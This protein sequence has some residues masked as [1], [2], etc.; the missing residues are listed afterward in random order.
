MN[1]ATAQSLREKG[2]NYHLNWGVSLQHLQEMAAEIREDLTTVPSGEV[3]TPPLG[4]VGRGFQVGRGSLFTLA[5]LL[6]KENIRE[7]KILATMLMPAEEFPADLAMLWVEQTPNQEIAEMAA[8]NLYQHLPYAKDMALQLIAQ[9]YEMAQLQGYCIMARLLTTDM[10]LDD[11]ELNEFIDQAQST[12]KSLTIK[13]Q[14][15]STSNVQYSISLRH[16]ILNAIQKLSRHTPHL[17]DFFE[18][19][20]FGRCN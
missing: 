17:N 8:M 5:S 6:W 2:V 18:V 4:E 9:P 19:V 12:F 16:A 13:G 1:G 10:V 15:S 7:C 20:F 3:V 11:S 14:E